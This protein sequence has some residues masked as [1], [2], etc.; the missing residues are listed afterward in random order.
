MYYRQGYDKSAH[1]KHLKAAL[2]HAKEAAS[3]LQRPLDLLDDEGELPAAGDP[4]PM[5]FGDEY[6]NPEM[7]RA[8]RAAL[9]ILRALA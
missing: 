6:D 7:D 1:V 9:G 5:D 3:C 8:R 4:G 2:F